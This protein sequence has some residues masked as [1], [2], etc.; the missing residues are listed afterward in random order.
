MIVN[1][2]VLS[3]AKKATV[4][5]EEKRRKNRDRQRKYQQSLTQDQIEEIKRKKREYAKEKRKKTLIAELDEKSKKI[6]RGEWAKTKRE[7]RKKHNQKSSVKDNS[8][9]KKTFGRKKVRRDRSAAYRT[10]EKLKKD[11]AKEKTKNETLKKENYR[12]N[13]VKEDFLT[14]SPKSKVKKMISEAHGKVNLK[15]YKK[16]LVGEVITQNLQEKTDSNSIS[17]KRKVTNVIVN[18]NF[19]KYKLSNEV[20]SFI[21]KKKLSKGILSESLKKKSCLSIKEGSQVKQFLEDDQN[22]T[23]CPG[24]KDTKKKMQ[25]RYL[26]APLKIL[27][28]KYCEKFLSKISFETFKKLKPFWIVKPKLSCRDTCACTKCENFQ[29]LIDALHKLGLILTKNMGDIA[30]SICCDYK[31]KSCIYRECSKCKLKKALAID[32]NYV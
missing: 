29:F 23:M 11:L 18:Q 28:Q 32:K 8:Q 4:G 26:S 30:K 27:H 20:K 3:M 10:I 17:E 9:I 15:I 14:N 21:S 24:K 7:Y 2:S 25:K 16:L 6:I 31:N 19:K 1:Y 12:S 22:S 13:N 5:I